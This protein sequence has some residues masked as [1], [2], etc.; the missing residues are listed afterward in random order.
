MVLSFALAVI[1]VIFGVGLSHELNSRQ[2]GLKTQGQN[3]ITETE[4]TKLCLQLRTRW[5]EL[6]LAQSDGLHAC[7]VAAGRACRSWCSSRLQRCR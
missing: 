3:D 2:K 6:C 7:P 4:C 1:G 5:N